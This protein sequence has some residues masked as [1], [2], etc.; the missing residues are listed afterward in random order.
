MRVRV[1]GMIALAMLTAACGSLPLA[2]TATPTPSATPSPTST[3]RPAETSTP[4]PT[5]A[6]TPAVTVLGL[7]TAPIQ[8][9]PSLLAAA[10]DLAERLELPEG[11]EVTVKS[12]TEREW[13]DASLGCPQPGMV[14]AQVITPGYVVVIEAEGEEYTYHTDTRGN[15]VACE[16]ED[17]GPNKL[18]PTIKDGSP[19]QPIGTAGPQRIPSPEK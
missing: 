9:E 5:V 4:K 13:S 14:Y 10:A 11:A 8:A 7:A 6:P 18:D 3:P 2:V 17:A 12:V 19:N 15:A 1:V 16:Q